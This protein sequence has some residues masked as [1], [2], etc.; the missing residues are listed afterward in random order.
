MIIKFKDNYIRRLCNDSNYA[1]TELPDKVVDSLQILLNRLRQYPT[2]STMYGPMMQKKFR[3][4]PLK[5]EKKG[6]ISLSLDKKYR[7]TL[8]VS[9]EKDING[10]D[11]IKL[12]EISNHYGD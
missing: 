5:G 4:H 3:T 9:E 8:T 6:I 2:F 7:M 11:I 10:E 1:R 12:L